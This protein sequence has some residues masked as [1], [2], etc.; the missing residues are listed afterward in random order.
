MKP[1]LP[2]SPEIENPVSEFVAGVFDNRFNDVPEMKM[3]R[4]T[5]VRIANANPNEVID[6]LVDIH[7]QIGEFV[8][9]TLDGKFKEWTAPDDAGTED[10]SEV[11]GDA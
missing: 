4:D 10:E 2:K 11:D 3:L 9:D 1:L 8:S 7:N 5:I 6:F